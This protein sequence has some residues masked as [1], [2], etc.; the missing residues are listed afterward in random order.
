MVVGAD[1]C[2]QCKSKQ[3]PPHLWTAELDRFTYSGPERCRL[4]AQVKQMQAKRWHNLRQV[5]GMGGD[6]P[7]SRPVGSNDDARRQLR[8]ACAKERERTCLPFRPAT[9]ADHRGHVQEAEKS[10]IPYKESNFDLK[11][12]PKLNDAAGFFLPRYYTSAAV[13]V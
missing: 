10:L 3:N 8:Q 5:P 11:A 9:A 12:A 13:F 1:V 4:P 6:N 2:R 7:Y